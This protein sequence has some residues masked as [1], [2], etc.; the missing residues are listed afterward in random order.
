MEILF[1][2]GL[3]GAGAVYL[4]KKKTATT[5]LSPPAPA[6]TYGGASAD[7]P[8]VAGSVGTVAL[9]NGAGYSDG[10]TNALGT[11][12]FR[13]PPKKV[14]MT[15]PTAKPRPIQT[16]KVVTAPPR[17]VSGRSNA[18][19]TSG[20]RVIAPQPIRTAPVRVPVKGTASPATFRPVAAAP[21]PT[22]TAGKSAA[23]T[24]HPSSRLGQ[25]APMHPQQDGVTHPL[26]STH[27]YTM[28]PAVTPQGQR[29]ISR[30]QPK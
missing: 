10:V 11:S 6:G 29:T 16:S 21:H 3:F 24:I 28:H 19:R 25:L 27:G 23:A 9:D 13:V 15:P 14:Q 30:N 1:L 17:L 8:N 22:L 12:A 26:S 2:I 18:I 20:G 4:L 5:V 7:S